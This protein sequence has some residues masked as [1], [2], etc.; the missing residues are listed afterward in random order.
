M[1][2]VPVC[3]ACARAGGGKSEPV[4]PGAGRE[5]S[6]ETGWHESGQAVQLTATRRLDGPKQKD[7]ASWPVP[8]GMQ[9][10]GKLAGKRTS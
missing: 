9:K 3:D 4:L 7:A 8:R 10:A 1:S 5:D 6:G 2:W